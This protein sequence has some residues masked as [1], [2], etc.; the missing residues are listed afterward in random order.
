VIVPILK[1]GKTAMDSTSY[2]PISLL[3]PCVKI[4]ERLLLPDVMAALPKH[5]FQDG[6]AQDH[7]CITALIPLV[8]S[9]ATGF[10]AP[11]PAKRSALCM[12]DISKVFNALDHTLLIE[13]ISESLLHPNIVRWLRV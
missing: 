2:R 6:F 10:N 7:S 1:V 8:T 11:K 4:M 5:P 9:I 12:L 3:S 13:K